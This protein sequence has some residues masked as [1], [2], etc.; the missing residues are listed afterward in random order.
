MG[1]ILLKKR[2]SY[3]TVVTIVVLSLM[4]S[5]AGAALT[6]ARDCCCSSK[7]HTDHKGIA[8]AM[9]A[10]MAGCCN[11]TDECPCSFKKEA[12]FGEK[13]FIHTSF[14]TGKKTNHFLYHGTEKGSDIPAVTINGGYRHF[15]EVRGRSA[16]IFLQVQSFL[17]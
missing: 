9:K 13:H 16:P 15:T 3:I 6:A 4:V 1:L 11:V 7:T 10:P 14:P 5:N 8:V 17:S 2:P 12:G